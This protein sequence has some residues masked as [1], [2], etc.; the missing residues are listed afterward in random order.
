[1]KIKKKK[2]FGVIRFVT[3]GIIFL[4]LVLS[5]VFPLFL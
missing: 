4:S 3:I 5:L 1:M 2:I